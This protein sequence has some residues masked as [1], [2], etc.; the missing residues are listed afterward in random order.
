MSYTF[1]FPI[2]RRGTDSAKWSYYGPDTLPMWVADMDFV[3]PQ[4]ILDALQ[5][6][7]AQGVFG[8]GSDPDAL[9]TVLVDRMQRLYGWAIQQEQIVFLPGLVCGLNV[10]S[11]AVGTP[12]DGVLVTTPVYPPF[13]SAPIN[14]QRVVHAAPLAQHV[15]GKRLHYTVDFDA[16]AGA[17]QHNTRLFIL[18]NPHNPTGV[19]YSRAELTRMAEL[20]EAN[21]LVICSDEIHCDLMLDGAKHIPIASLSPAIA[22][23]TVTLMAPSKTFNI[24]GLG[25]SFAIVPNPALRKQVEHAA[26]GIVPHLNILGVIA[27]E[28]AYTQCDAWLQALLVYLQQNRD[29]AVNYI[30]EYFPDIK[31]TCP[32]AT[33]LLWLDCRDAGIKGNAQK[34]FLEQAHVA[35]ND[36]KIFGDDGDGFV[37]LNFGC[38]RATLVAG[39]EQMRQALAKQNA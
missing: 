16:M 12:G 15:T 3:S 38:P 31:V 33:Y 27:A 9:R 10:V 21:D 25:A 29:F 17:I 7:V 26:L 23:R 6:R 24:P 14:Q 36:G 22:Q 19:A 32:D 13:L 39:L 1:D 11:R 18:C 4:P 20:C 35:V 34:F 37:R 2:Q 8:Y 28:A 30:E 5:A